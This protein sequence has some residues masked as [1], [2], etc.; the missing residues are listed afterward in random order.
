MLVLLLSTISAIG[1]HGTS[2]L[3][4]WLYVSH[5]AFL[6]GIC[7]A[8]LIGILICSVFWFHGVGVHVKLALLL[9]TLRWAHRTGLRLK[10]ENLPLSGHVELFPFFKGLSFSCFLWKFDSTVWHFDFMELF[11]RQ[12]CS[13]TFDNFRQFN[14]TEPASSLFDFMFRTRHFW[15]ACLIG[16][17]ICSV[18]WFRNWRSRQI[19]LLLSTLRWAHRT[20]LRTMSEKF[21]PIGA[22][23][24]IF[25][26]GGTFFLLICLAVW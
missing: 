11:S 19:A 25:N 24:I 12:A 18:F 16:V 22:R 5:T 10:S 6:E 15:R 21:A 20:G 7:W 17:L 23:W 14:F 13:S 1:F 9:S 3:T 8:C 2:K 4:V 26:F